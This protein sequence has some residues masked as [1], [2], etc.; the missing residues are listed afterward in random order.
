MQRPFLDL[1][2]ANQPKPNLIVRF[3]LHRSPQFSICST[4]LV[5]FYYIGENRSKGTNPGVVIS[6]RLSWNRLIVSLKWHAQVCL[7]PKCSWRY[8]ESTN[9]WVHLNWNSWATIGSSISINRYLDSRGMKRW[10]DG[11]SRR[12]ALKKVVAMFSS[13]QFFTREANLKLYDPIEL[14]AALLCTSWSDS[15]TIISSKCSL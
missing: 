9:G 15:P 12:D 8:L 1:E 2:S 7:T 11:N 14:K 6:G 5:I 4:S 13:L 10:L 3:P